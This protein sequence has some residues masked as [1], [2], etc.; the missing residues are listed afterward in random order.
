L[1]NPPSTFEQE[2]G[3]LSAAGAPRP[4]LN[5]LNLAAT[6]RQAG[7]E[8][9]ILDAASTGISL[10]PFV[11]QVVGANPDVVG[12]SAMTAHIHTAGRLAAR[13]KARLPSV[14]VVVGGAHVSALPE[15]TMERWPAFD[16]GVVGEGDLTIVEL[17]EALDEGRD[18]EAVPGLVV[19]RNGRRLLTRRRPLI[20]DLDTLPFPAWDLLPDF[21][22]LYQPTATRRVRLPSAYLV[23]SRGCP[24]RCTFCSNSVHGRTFRSY[25]VDYLMRMVE[26]LIDLFGVRD[27]T[28]YDENLAVNRQRLV[29]LCRRLIEA[30]H[31]LT[32]SCDARADNLGPDLTALMYRAGC[33]SVWMGMESGDPEMLARYRKG[34]SIDDYRRAT[35]WCKQA[36]LLCNGSFIIGGPGETRASLRRS[37]AF[38]RQVDLDYF[39]P[40]Y[41]TPL[42]GAPMYNEVHKH[43]TF[44]SDYSL[45]TMTFPTFIPHGLTARELQVWYVWSLFAFY[46]RPAKL[47]FVL[48]QM[49][50]RHFLK[51]LGRT[52]V[53]LLHWVGKA[54]WGRRPW[55]SPRGS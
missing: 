17:M 10:Q 38:A 18:L 35:R 12:I 27:I 1:I 21:T 6:A 46:I 14:P 11:E 37:L 33:R 2:F 22:T 43:G 41:C 4:P 8:I 51:T 24:Y 3:I 32:W 50:P 15:E 36:G 42:P 16:V 49:G 34:T 40:F 52:V 25:S 7:H 54:V 39:T 20:K 53:N 26:H 44:F 9:R 31:D 13:L 5:L 55:A 28:V 48:E 29:E 47:L 19:R 45:A 30:D 23:S